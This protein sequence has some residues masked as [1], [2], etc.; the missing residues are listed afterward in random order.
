MDNH[1][2]K[3]FHSTLQFQPTSK[4]RFYLLLYYSH[5]IHHH[6]LQQCRSSN[7]RNKYNYLQK[8]STDTTE[9]HTPHKQTSTTDKSTYT[10]NHQHTSSINT[11]DHKQHMVQRHRQQEADADPGHQ[12]DSLE[13]LQQWQ[14]EQA[15]AVESNPHFKQNKD[16]HSQTHH[17]HKQQTPQ[18]IRPTYLT[19]YNHKQWN[20][21]MHCLCCR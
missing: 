19:H 11:M 12:A 7:S 16:Q 8:Q 10:W 18:L 4:T 21:Q 14:M 20:T 2:N 5:F 1:N 6:N 15:A 17:N 9:Q 13:H 3:N